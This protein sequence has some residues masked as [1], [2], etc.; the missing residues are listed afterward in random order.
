MLE[1]A[2]AKFEKGEFEITLEK[3]PPKWKA[4]FV[5]LGPIRGRLVALAIILFAGFLTFARQPGSLVAD[6][7]WVSSAEAAA[8]VQDYA[9]W[10]VLALGVLVY[11]MVFVFKKQQ[12]ILN[13]I[14]AKK[15]FRYYEEAAFKGQVPQEGLYR[16][17]DLKEFEV[18]GPEKDPEAPCGF[19][20]LKFSSP[21]MGGEKDFKFRML[22]PDQIKIYPTNLARILEK[23][24]TG[25]WVDP[26]A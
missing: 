1:L 14:R 3:V 5:A 8:K 2:R 22:T 12:I 13:F 26:D 18:I 25:D 4:P 23:D 16:F 17:E 10:S 6:K 7:K 21:A 24:P 20:H 9:T 19:I 11:L 15:E